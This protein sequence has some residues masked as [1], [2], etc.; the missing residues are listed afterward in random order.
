MRMILAL[1]IAITLAC[2]VMA[3]AVIALAPASS[4]PGGYSDGLS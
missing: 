3:S 4:A 2:G 1:L